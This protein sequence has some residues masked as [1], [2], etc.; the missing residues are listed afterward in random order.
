MI[1]PYLT[2]LTFLCCF[3]FY[4]QEYFPKND[5][6]V[7][8]NTNYTAFTN[9]KIYVTPT[10]VIENGTLL[11]KDGK[12]VATGTS[13]SIPKNTKIIDVS[14][15]SIYPSFIDIYSDFGIKAPERDSGSGRSAQYEPSRSGYY[16]NDHV[17][18]ENKAID[19][20]SFDSKKASEYIKA[21][22]GTLNAHIQDGIVRG[23]GMLVALDSEGTNANRILDD[24]SAQYF[25]FSKS[26]TSRQ[27]YP[28]S[29][30]GSMALLR[31]LYIDADWYAKGN[32]KTKDLSLEALNKNKSL[33]QIFA[34]GSRANLLRADK[35]GDEYGVQY[36]ILG[37]G[38]EYERVNEVKNT[39]ASL[40]IP[41]NFPDAYDVE[42][43]FLASGLSLS[44][45]RA[46]NQKPTNPKVLAENNIKFALTTHSL[47][48]PKEFKSNLLKAIEYGL[49]EE[50]ALESL[51][52]I[53][54]QL[55]GKQNTIGS[56]KNE[57]YANF[58]ITSGNIF[59]K[60]TTL[61]EN[62]V[63]GQQNVI[64]DMTIKDIRGD[65]EFRLAG[66]DYKMSLKGELSK[67]KSEIISGDNTLGS[68]VS[69]S[70]NWV[71]ISMTTKD[72]TKQEFVR[73]I[74]NVDSDN[75]LR[76]TTTMPTGNEMSFYAKSLKK[77]DDTKSDD[78][79]KSKDSTEKVFPVTFP[80]N[81]YGF[82]ELPKAE[83][84]LFKNATVWT[85]EADG[86]LENTDVLIKNGKIA[87]IGQNLSDNSAKV[88]DATGKHLTA[89]VID[90]H[91]HIAAA[92][93]N[94]GGQNSS[95]EVS[96]EDVVEPGDISIYRNLAGG[97]TSIQIL[98]G[99]ANPIG[100]RSAIIKLKWGESA[101]NLIYDNSPKF[102][103]FALGENVKQSNWSSYSRFPQTRMGVEQLYIDYFTRAKEYDALKKSGK[104][105]RKDIELEVLA[106]ILNKERF[107]SCHSYVQS[108]IN[109][110]MKVAEKFNF[111]INTFTHILEGYKLADKMKEHGV[112]GSTFS[113]WWAYKYEVNDAI[114]YNAA[115]MH[116]QGVTVAINSDDGEMSRRLNQEAAKSVKYGGVSE[117]EAWKFVTLNPAKL[118]HI[119]DRVGSIKVGKDADVVLWT[120][121]PLS[122][123]AKAEKTI[124]EGV[125][126][127]DLKRD[128]M[129]RSKIQNE[130]SELINLMLQAKNKGLKTQPI[131]KKEKEFLH[132]DSMDNEHHEH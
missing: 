10:Q 16:W 21:G 19:R 95:A 38:D 102:I 74:A 101:D 58:L 122:I 25:S 4:A 61:Y 83:T 109:M 72:S 128:E 43:P 12:V 97:V 107:I 121:H 104:P 8:T 34:A 66:E 132:C 87:K 24:H 100:G 71:T 129:M 23:S 130:K 40:I 65:Y 48:S 13:V 54:A 94:E 90:E 7:A 76:G 57:T 2:I 44:D 36:V 62:W 105:Y 59:D 55:L 51:T 93:I 29:I 117:E 5:G 106:E 3:S 33:I 89:G 111:N 125:T 120:D 103:K 99:S 73:I 56:L 42:N 1:R 82:T 108:E 46:W 78:K 32:S 68:K 126:Y 39:N 92:S 49:S 81:A 85:N 11:I 63:L 91:S 67:L 77:E 20:F 75:N 80:N 22:F 27:S 131:K 18:P 35:V 70:D 115:I 112:G 124:I 28:S 114:P 26:V 52:T 30:M 110:L 37:G 31:Q 41:I 53:P 119:D 69:Y 88:I 47:K 79:K 118:L 113:D 123:Y 96:I 64:E 116:N 14:G 98:H 9:A 60:K 50:K 6:V 15:K 86:I 45:M 17:M 84:L 127:F